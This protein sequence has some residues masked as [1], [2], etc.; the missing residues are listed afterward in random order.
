MANKFYSPSEIYED[1]KDGSFK[2]ESAGSRAGKRVRDSVKKA[3]GKAKKIRKNIKDEDI[4]LKDGSLRS[5]KVVRK[6]NPRTGKSDIVSY[7]DRPIGSAIKSVIG[8][9]KGGK[10]SSWQ[11]HVT[12]KYG[13]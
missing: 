10:V 13:K 9:K 11:D 8:F 7:N 5:K 3:V 12:S 1:I 4:Y 2:Y 6:T